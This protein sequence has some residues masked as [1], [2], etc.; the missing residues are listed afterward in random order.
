[1]DPHPRS[2]HRTPT[3]THLLVGLAGLF[4]ATSLPG[5]FHPPVG[6]SIAA[7]EPPEVEGEGWNSP[8]A[9]E[10]VDR[11]RRTRADALRDTDLES[12]RARTQG[13]VYFYV[14]P[15]EPGDRIL[16]RVDQVAVDHFWRAPDQSHQ[17]VVGQRTETKAPIRDFNYFLDRLTLVQYGMGDTIEVGHGSDVSDVPHPL[18]VQGPEGPPEE[19]YDYRVADS[20][21][22]SLPGAEAPIEI[23]RLDVRPRDPDRPGFVGSIDV[24]R[25][26]GSIVRMAFTVTPASYQDPRNDRVQVQLE[27]GLWDGRHWLPHEQRIEV[28]REMPQLDLGAGTVIESVLRVG[29]YELDAPVDHVFRAPWS[30]TQVSFRP[31]AELRDFEFDE[32]LLDRLE[33][34][35]LDGARTVDPGE[36]RQ[37]ARETGQTRARG[38]LPSVRPHLPNLSTAVRYN[39]AEGW[40]TGLGVTAWPRGSVRVRARGAYAFGA[41]HPVGGTEVRVD[42]GRRWHLE[43]SG[44]YRETED[45]GLAPGSPELVN[46]FTAA[47]GA[48]DDRDPFFRSGVGAQLVRPAERLDGRWALGLEYRR[49]RTATSVREVAPWS[50]DREHRAL[51]PV[52]DGEAVAV[53]ITH[54]RSRPWTRG[55]QLRTHG[56]AEVVRFDGSTHGRLQARWE[57]HRS[58]REGE[59]QL[60][61]TLRLGT[62][63]G[64]APPQ[65]HV[66]LGGRGTIPGYRYRTM[67]GR[68]YGVLDLTFTHAVLPQ[69]LSAR[70]NARAGWAGGASAAVREAWDAGASRG[71]RPTAGAGVGLYRDLLNVDLHRGLVDGRWAVDVYIAPEW[72]GHL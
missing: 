16:L 54:R 12:Y 2:R 58:V 63:T 5:S 21:R 33:E 42:P 26:T 51:R 14:D 36:I 6:M 68:H 17:M 34:E 37:W 49:D 19:L 43:L 18:A 60:D 29:D 24:E 38:G 62:A 23:R 27:Y 59:G 57:A 72:W 25:D 30:T 4:L 1:M 3:R 28:R 20:L 9:L 44:Q 70:V 48:R 52:T 8:E 67:V 13:H 45:L 71:V 69:W 66:L 10:L 41:E 40:A 61:G 56:S 39:R 46:T 64:A 47:S 31:E 53:G 32:G 7:Q 35:G 50:G 22:L 15:D 11:G 55:W 65:A